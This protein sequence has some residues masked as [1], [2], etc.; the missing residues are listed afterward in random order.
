MRSGRSL[1]DAEAVRVEELPDGARLMIWRYRADL[2]LGEESFGS[3]Y[4][5]SE[6][7]ILRTDAPSPVP[8]TGVRSAPLSCAILSVEQFY[9]ESSAEAVAFY[10]LFV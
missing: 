3:Y 7:F 6:P 5:Y 10:L 9:C 4:M 2:M 1:E 8:K